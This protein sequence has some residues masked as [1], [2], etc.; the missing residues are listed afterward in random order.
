MVQVETVRQFNIDGSISYFKSDQ[1]SLERKKEIEENNKLL[2]ENFKT[3]T[4]KAFN[5]KIEM[6]KLF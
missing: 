6:A 3:A 2:F 5:D 1:L 4:I